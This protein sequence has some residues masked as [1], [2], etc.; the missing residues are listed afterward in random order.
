MYYQAAPW[1]DCICPSLVEVNQLELSCPQLQYI[2]QMN[3][4]RP[5][6]TIMADKRPS[7]HFFQTVFSSITDTPHPQ[8]YWNCQKGFRPFFPK[9][10]KLDALGLIC[11][12]SFFL[13]LWSVVFN[14]SRL[15]SLRPRKTNIIAFLQNWQTFNI[16]LRKIDEWRGEWY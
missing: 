15:E 12:F 16:A 13:S 4:N 9:S 3:Y 5:D 7:W 10:Q 2:G 1:V 8:N 14:I 6:I 11:E